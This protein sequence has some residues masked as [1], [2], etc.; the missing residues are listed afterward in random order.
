MK[1]S[2]TIV[3]AALTVGTFLSGASWSVAHA[4]NIAQSAPKRTTTQPSPRPAPTQQIRSANAYFESRTRTAS[5]QQRRMGGWRLDAHQRG[6]ARELNRESAPLVR[7]SSAVGAPRGAVTGGGA[8]TQSTRESRKLNSNHG[9]D[10]RRDRRSRRTDR[11]IDARL[12]W[13]PRESAGVRFG[14][15]TDARPIPRTRAITAPQFPYFAPGPATRLSKLPP[16]NRQHRYQG[17]DWYAIDGRWFQRHHSSG[18]V[19]VIPAVGFVTPFLPL[20]AVEV[21]VDGIRYYRAAGVSYRE[22]AGE[23]L[24]VESLASSSASGSGRERDS[25]QPLFY[26][27]ASD[28][29]AEPTRGQSESDFELDAGRCL[30]RAAADSDYNPSFGGTN[31]DSD[32]AGEHF[33]DFQAMSRACLELAGYDIY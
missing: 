12:P 29:Y 33:N 32:A 15:V 6:M 17:R 5:P 26:S 13:A 2:I 24:V 30:A 8:F 7:R 21:E 31:S 1:I 28:L 23:Y 20:G 10:R 14:T 22:M 16:R 4:Q 3:V 27:G 19:S 9:H 11:A 25:L 18:Y